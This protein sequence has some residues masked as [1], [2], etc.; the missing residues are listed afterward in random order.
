M[1]LLYAVAKKN[2][3]SVFLNKIIVFFWQPSN[4]FD[5]IFCCF[6]NDWKITKFERGFYSSDFE[7]GCFYKSSKFAIALCF[8]IKLFATSLHRPKLVTLPKG[9]ISL[10]MVSLS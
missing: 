4:T 2:L 6:Y 8:G 7:P 10:W 5:C 9:I 1:L 3:V